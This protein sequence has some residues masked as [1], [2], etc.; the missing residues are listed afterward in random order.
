LRA[1]RRVGDVS[2]GLREFVERHG[3]RLAREYTSHGVGRHMHEE[4]TITNYEKAGTG[5]TLRPNMVIALEPMVLVSTAETR[6]LRDQWTVVSADGALTAHFEHTV[7]VTENEP[8]I[9]TRMA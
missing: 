5:M 6:V 2:T 3:F 9:L 4:P 7:L 1:G 8:E